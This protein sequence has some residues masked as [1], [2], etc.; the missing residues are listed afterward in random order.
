MFI[1]EKGYHCVEEDCP[2]F[3]KNAEYQH[4]IEVDIVVHGKWKLNVD[5]SATCLICG[6]K[7]PNAWD[8][9]NSDNYCHHCGAK[10][11]LLKFDNADKR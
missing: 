5:G 11:D 1:C 10:M 4:M 7:Q 6:R 3:N 2:I 8:Y 9:D